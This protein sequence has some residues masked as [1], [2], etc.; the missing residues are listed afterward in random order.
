M[1]ERVMLKDKT[2][3]MTRE[4]EDAQEKADETQERLS[5]ML[6][7][8]EQ[9]VRELENKYL[10]AEELLQV[11]CRSKICMKKVRKWLLTFTQ[12]PCREELLM[13]GRGSGCGKTPSP[14]SSRSTAPPSERRGSEKE[15]REGGTGGGKG[16][17]REGERAGERESD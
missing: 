5:G 17:G 8:S 14:W 16:R 12:L 15:G 9:R 10:S 7:Q 4:L 13:K 3:Q 1:H 6:K 2:E 11:R